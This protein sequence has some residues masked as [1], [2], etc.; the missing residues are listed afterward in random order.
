MRR[1]I[2]T[3]ALLGLI[4]A[5]L[6]VHLLVILS[7][8]QRATAQPMPED[9]ER[10]MQMMRTTP[11]QILKAFLTDKELPRQLATFN[12][13]LY[14]A[15]RKQGFSEEQALQLVIHTNWMPGAR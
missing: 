5:A 10:W 12:R 13:R 3:R 8:G 4:A 2:L 15:Y 7:M 1:D 9:R 14:D 6:I 11:L